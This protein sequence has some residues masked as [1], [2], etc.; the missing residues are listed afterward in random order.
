MLPWLCENNETSWSERKAEPRLNYK[1]SSVE[2]FAE[3]RSVSGDLADERSNVST[4]VS[5][6]A[7]PVQ[8]LCESNE[9]PCN[10]HMLFWKQSLESWINSFV[11]ANFVGLQDQLEREWDK[12]DKLL[13][14]V[15]LCSIFAYCHVPI[16]SA[17]FPIRKAN[18][19]ATPKLPHRAVRRVSRSVSQH[20]R[21][22][23]AV[24]CRAVLLNFSGRS[25]K[26]LAVLRTFQV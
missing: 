9:R 10:V 2:S 8:V 1:K 12:T 20:Q 24:A 18:L 26:G 15:Q 11:Y 7:A 23:N 4:P 22:H 3:F 14:L 5:S 21:S 17:E 13:A 25:F 19:M 16:P 6:A